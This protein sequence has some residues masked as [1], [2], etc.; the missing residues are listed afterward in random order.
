MELP[1]PFQYPKNPHIRSHG[2]VGYPDYGR[3]KPFLRDEFEFRCVYCLERER[4]YPNRGDSFSTEHFTPKSVQADRKTDYEN[5]VYSCLRCNC[6]KTTRILLLDPT[7]TAFADHVRVSEDGR[8]IGITPE[9]QDLID[10]L[11]LD[12]DRAVEVRRET[13][14]LL[15]IKAKHPSDSNVHALYLS[16]FGYP[17]D[18]PDLK[19]LRP[20]GGN[21]KPKG[22][23]RCHFEREK[24][25]LLPDVY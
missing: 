22:V 18:L 4:W 1:T 24:A 20:P 7:R 25:G 13:L 5:L 16:R 19:V 10:L 17:K 11:D 12:Q 2:P 8:I 23:E 14:N 9:G 15:Q 3:Y 6:F 21:L